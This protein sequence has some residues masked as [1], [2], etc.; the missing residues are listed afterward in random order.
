LIELHSLHY[1]APIYTMMA[2]LGQVYS[3]VNRKN[4]L[5]AG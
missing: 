2:S 4:V 1:L 5:L 3:L